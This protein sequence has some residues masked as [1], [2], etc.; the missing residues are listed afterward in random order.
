VPS[1]NITASNSNAYVIPLVPAN[2]E[3]DISLAGVSYHLRIKWNSFSAAWI[4]YIEDSQQNPI[5]S[6]V[7]MVTGCDLLE[8]YAY[9]NIGGAMVVQ[10]TNDPTLVPNYASLGVTGNLFFITPVAA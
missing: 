9:L 2:Q 5:L 7:P 8:Q 4:L 10:S 3:F 6:G 1:S